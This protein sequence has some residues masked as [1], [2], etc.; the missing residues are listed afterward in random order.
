M[1][2]AL[3]SRRL[4]ICNRSVCLAFILIA[5]ALFFMLAMP[6]LFAQNSPR[7]T[8]VDPS[9]GKVNDTITI[10]GENLEKPH[11]SGVFLSD[12]T[13]DYKA[14]VVDE[15]ADKIVVKVP[16]VTPGDYNVSIQV[17]NSIFIQPVRFTVQQ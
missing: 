15:S 16:Q 8:S 12:K 9:S 6:S 10:S 13:K 14:S 5:A 11:V 7:V 17:G 1:A 4:S 3:V 2:D